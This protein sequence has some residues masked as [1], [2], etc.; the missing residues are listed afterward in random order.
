MRIVLAVF[1]SLLTVCPAVSEDV[2][3]MGLGTTTCGRFANLYKEKPQEWEEYFFIW[4][5]GY[6]TGFNAGQMLMGQPTSNLKG[7][8]VPEQK[9][10]I[11]QFCDTHPLGDYYEAVFALLLSLRK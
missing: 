10:F 4:A 2:T 11:R 3:E 6:M 7:K 5:Q 8:T 1:F 9:A